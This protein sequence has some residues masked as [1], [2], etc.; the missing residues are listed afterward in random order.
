MMRII[1]S[2]DEEGNYVLSIQ[3]SNKSEVKIIG[4][5]EDYAQMNE[6]YET[7]K[8]IM[9]AINKRYSIADLI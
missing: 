5:F 8:V 2:V 6:H 3:T 7:T 9:K 1:K 4:I